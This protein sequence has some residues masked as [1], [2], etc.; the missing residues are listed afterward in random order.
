MLASG[1][2]CAAR[3]AGEQ[4]KMSVMN[5]LFHAVAS[6]TIVHACRPDTR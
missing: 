1:L 3:R 2:G 6:G 4:R 5:S